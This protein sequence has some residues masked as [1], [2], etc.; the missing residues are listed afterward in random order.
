MSYSDLAWS[1][2]SGNTEEA[3]RLI[4]SGADVNTRCDKGQT[5]L[6]QVLAGL[7]AGLPVKGNL[8]SFVEVLLAHGLVAD[9]K[10]DA[11]KTALMYAADGGNAPV[12]GLLVAKG[13]DVNARDNGDRT[14]LMAAAYAVSGTPEA[15]VRLL[16]DNGADVNAVNSPFRLSPLMSA[17]SRDNE[18]VA[19]LL[20]QNGANT[21]ATNLDGRTALDVAIEC[22]CK[23]VANLLRGESRHGKRQ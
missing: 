16:I 22:D 4:A 8:T 20:I 15:V 18:A 14:A 7:A 19:R 9:A 6:M 21:R 12:A 2:I 23:K 17:A 11:G 1:G 5:A 3:A 10:D 13:A